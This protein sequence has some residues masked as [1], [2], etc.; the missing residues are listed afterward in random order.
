MFLL[1]DDVDYTLPCQWRMESSHY[2]MVVYPV[3]YDYQRD[4]NNTQN[5]CRLAPNGSRRLLMCM[6]KT[7][8]SACT[9]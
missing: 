1:S 7:R 4:T 6:L 5:K 2:V 8:L 9:T 3:S